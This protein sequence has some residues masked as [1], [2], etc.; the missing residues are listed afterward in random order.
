MLRPED[1]LTHRLLPTAMAACAALATVAAC[2]D[3][4]DIFIEE[5]SL[6]VVNES[7]FVVEELYLAEVNDPVFGPNLLAGDVL[8]PGEQILIGATCGFFDVLI[9]DEEGVECEIDAI[10]LCLNDATFVIRN[11]TC[12]VFEAEAKRRAAEAAAK[13]TPGA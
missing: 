1:M 5:G 8:F 2:T 11:D 3:D 10:D 13:T 7:D 4:D 12:T 9:V 6:L